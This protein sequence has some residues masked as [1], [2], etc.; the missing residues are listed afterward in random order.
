[1][2]SKGTRVVYDQS[3]GGSKVYR[4]QGGAYKSDN[5]GPPG[6][7]WGTDIERSRRE[8]KIQK[9]WRGELS[10][11]VYL[12]ACLLHLGGGKK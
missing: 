9:T 5:N 7:V 6:A 12:M 1:M 2:G 10:Q 11:L 4:G 8:D 3:T